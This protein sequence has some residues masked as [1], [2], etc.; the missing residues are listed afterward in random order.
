VRFHLLI[1]GGIVKDA[2]V[3]AFGCPHT[4][5]VA[6]WLCQELKGHTREALP[7]GTPADWAASRSVPVEKLGRLLVI[8]DALRACLLQWS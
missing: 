7:P 4:L 8:E 6:G 1:E 2:R 3:Q 5:D